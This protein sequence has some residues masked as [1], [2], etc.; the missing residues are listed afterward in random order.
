MIK[1]LF[2]VFV[3]F[4]IFFFLVFVLFLVSFVLFFEEFIHYFFFIR[5]K[6]PLIFVN[7][8]KIFPLF[9][10]PSSHLLFLF[11]SPFSLSIIVKSALEWFD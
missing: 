2:V 1:K 4:L 5:N 7:L 8:V 6:S 11:L 10:L 3:R 9:P